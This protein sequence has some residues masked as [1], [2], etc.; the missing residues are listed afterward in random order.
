MYMN[1]KMQIKIILY[2][3]NKYS[4]ESY[5]DFCT[6]LPKLCS[7]CAPAKQVLVILAYINLNHYTTWIQHQRGIGMIPAYILLSLPGK[8]SK[9]S[10]EISIYPRSNIAKKR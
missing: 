9:G 1:L 5:C 3:S 6:S 2:I 10:T 8:K 4:C 7:V